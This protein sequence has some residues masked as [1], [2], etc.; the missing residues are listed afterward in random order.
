VTAVVSASGSLFP[1]LADVWSFHGG[2]GV[3]VGR[4]DNPEF[5]SRT[6]PNYD[7][8]SPK[9]DPNDPSYD[10]NA[11]VC[12]PTTS[13]TSRQGTV[14]GSIALNGGLAGTWVTTAFDVSYAPSVNY[15]A[16]RS[17]LDNAS[18]R[19]TSSWRHD[20][21]PRASLDL[22]EF[23]TY[24]P[25]QNLDPNQLQGNNVLVQRTRTTTSNFRGVFAFEKSEKTTLTWTYRYQERA[26]SSDDYVDNASH[27]ASMDYRRRIGR[28]SSFNTGYEYGLFSYKGRYPG[29]EHHTAHVGYGFSTTGGFNA[30]ANVGY[31]I[32]YPDDPSQKNADGIF[33]GAQV[34]YRTGPFS[35]TFGYTRGIRNGGG[36]FVTSRAANS[37]GNLRWEISR[38]LSAELTATYLVNERIAGSTGAPQPDDTIRTFNGRSTLTYTFSKSWHLTASY[39]H[40][41]QGRPPGVSSVP[42]LRSNRYSVG[43]SW[44]YR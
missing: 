38:A 26:F 37:Y 2:A 31:D 8:N 29:A 44:S 11:S 7:P 18:H 42:D 39:T 24:T 32:L 40:Y 10:P 30:S 3:N 12:Q 16:D 27:A 33:T 17:G 14:T 25:E 23:L 4:T 41:R 13:S 43:V 28:R 5:L 22:N 21:S 6:N 35:S 36:V 1:V 19:L 34:G 20:Y 15:Y 9:C